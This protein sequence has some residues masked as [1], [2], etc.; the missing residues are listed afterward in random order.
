L[1]IGVVGAGLRHDHNKHPILRP[2]KA[3]QLFGLLTSVHCEPPVYIC[4]TCT[5]QRK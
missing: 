4:P 2:I 3:A 5:M 1:L